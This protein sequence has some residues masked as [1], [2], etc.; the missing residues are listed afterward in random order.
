MSVPPI[1]AAPP[2]GIHL[3]SRRCVRHPARE[4]AARCPGCHRFFC[5]ECVVEHAGK[6]LC[7]ACLARLTAAAARRRARLAGLRRALWSAAGAL[8]LWAMFYVSGALLLKIPS[9]YH[10]G[11]AWRRSAEGLE[12]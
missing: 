7:A 10:D 3:H 11:T 6:L 12:P 4:A 5:R 1:S 2:T 9:E 8:L